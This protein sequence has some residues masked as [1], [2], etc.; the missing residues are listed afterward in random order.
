VFVQ[1]AQFASK[2]KGKSAIN[3]ARWSTLKRESC[4]PRPLSFPFIVRSPR[5]P[6]P[7]EPTWP[8]LN[9]VTQLETQ[10]RV[11]LEAKPTNVPVEGWLG[12]RDDGRRL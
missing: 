3:F 7:S 1:A 11:E 10:L 9:D 8:S 6:R 12:A 2:L 4:S 5:D